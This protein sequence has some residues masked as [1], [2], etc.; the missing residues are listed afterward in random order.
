MKIDLNSIDREQFNVR[1]GVFCGESSFLITPAL[2][3]STWTRQ[4][5]IFRSSIWNKDGICLSA[6]LRKQVNWGEKPEQFPVPTDLTSCNIFNKEDGSLCVIDYHNDR[7]NLRTR[8]TFSIDDGAIENNDEFWIAFNKY[9]KIVDFLKGVGGN[10]S[11]LCEHLSARPEKQI[12]IKHKVTDF[13]LIGCVYKYDY[14]YFSQKALDGL[15]VSLDMPRP[16]SY[17]FNDIPLM[18]TDVKEW[19]G[20]E[21]VVIYHSNDQEFHKLKCDDYNRKHFF[22]SNLSLKGLVEFQLVNHFESQKCFFKYIEESL[23]FECAG[24]SENYIKLIIDARNQIGDDLLK[25]MKFIGLH[26]RNDR[27]EFAREAAIDLGDLMHL[28]F[29]FL[30]NKGIDRKTY[31]QLYYKKLNIKL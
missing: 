15:S 6:G 18:L 4:N 24:M 17:S 2:A 31:K 10:V 13:K 14:R 5:A 27:K 20:R 12:I 19:T 11:L 29:R 16:I 28:S 3:G 7:I 25:V 30:D 21:G 22:K 23:D 26:K 1:E 9:P 8:G